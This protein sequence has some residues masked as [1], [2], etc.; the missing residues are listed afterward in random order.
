MNGGIPS[1]S[2]P[3]TYAGPIARRTDVGTSHAAAASLKHI[4]GRQGRAILRIMRDAW[5]EPMAAEQIAAASFVLG[6][7]EVNRRLSD[8]ERLGHVQ[9][10]EF[11]HLNP[12]GRHAVKYALVN[13]NVNL[14]PTP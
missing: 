1:K 8:L 10:T 2:N 12:S 6:R 5:P 9:K 14:G 7:V 11:R 4:A 3:G 13:P